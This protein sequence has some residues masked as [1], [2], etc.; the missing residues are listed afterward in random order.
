M[1]LMKVQHPQPLSFADYLRAECSGQQRHEYLGGLV[2]AMA[3]GT[4]RHSQL[5]GNA[6]S[7][8]RAAHR[9]SHC[10]TH[11]SDMLLRLNWNGDTYAYY[12]DVFV[13]CE[14]QNPKQSYCESACLI[15]EVLS[16]STAR[17]D[18]VEKLSAYRNVP[19]LQAYLLVAQDGP[20]VTLFSAANG[21]QGETITEPEAPI[22]LPAC[23]NAAAVTL[24]LEAIYEGIF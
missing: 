14:A 15:V 2:V 6:F 17:I 24:T 20:Y 11:V 5:I 18:R 13:S 12:P 16:E 3:G 23:G 9:G 7:L 1:T 21:W 4:Q 19:G 8:L 10:I 22:A